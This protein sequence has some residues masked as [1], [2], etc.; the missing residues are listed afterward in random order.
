MHGKPQISRGGTGR[1]CA[2]LLLLLFVGPW[3]LAFAAPDAITD[4]SLPVCCQAH[5]K[6]KCFM[7]SMGQDGAASTSGQLALSHLSE[8]CPYNPS[9]STSPHRNSLGQPAKDVAA[10]GFSITSSPVAITAWPGSSLSSLANCKRG[11]P[12][13]A[14]SLEST[15]DRPATQPRLPLL[16]RHD[17][18]TKTDISSFRPHASDPAYAT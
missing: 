14:L 12:S 2:L 7:R 17:V 4:T 6:H 13:P 16:W 8:R 3:L 5:G 18:S 10:V 11:P 15:T 1:L 9:F